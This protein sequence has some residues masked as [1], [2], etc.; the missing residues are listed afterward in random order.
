MMS[1]IVAAATIAIV[2]YQKQLVK[3]ILNEST[4]DSWKFFSVI[5]ILIIGRLLLFNVNDTNIFSTS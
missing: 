5:V 4:V 2:F 1:V 3:N